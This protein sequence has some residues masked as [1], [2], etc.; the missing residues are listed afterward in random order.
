MKV[1]V[2]SLPY[3]F[4]VLYVLCFTR[5][6]YQVIVYRTIGPLVPLLM[7][8]EEQ[9]SVNIMAKECTLSSC[10]PPLGGLP[11]NSVVRITDHPE[12]T[13][14]GYRGC[15]APANKQKTKQKKTIEIITKTFFVKN[16]N[17]RLFSFIY[18]AG[19]TCLL[20]SIANGIVTPSTLLIDFNSVAS[21]TCTTGYTFE[22]PT[23]TSMR[24]MADRNVNQIPKCVGE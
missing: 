12:M 10:K 22:D 13:S 6:R 17:S 4:Q 18:F 14:D 7:I 24:C 20:P 8:Q 19:K 23:I 21:V 16:K 3:I 15:K 2:I 11:R 9:L 5:P 1:K